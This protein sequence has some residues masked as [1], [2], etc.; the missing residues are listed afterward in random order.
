MEKVGLDFES[1]TSV[2]KDLKKRLGI[3]L[4]E[5]EVLLNHK[6]LCLTFI[7]CKTTILF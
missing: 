7:F 3:L 6:I 4:T 5:M 2:M 1:M